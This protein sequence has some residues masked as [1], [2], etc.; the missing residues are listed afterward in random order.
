MSTYLNEA[1][2]QALFKAWHA[3]WRKGNHA[4][5]TVNAKKVSGLF[6]SDPEERTYARYLFD[7]LVAEGY[8]AIES[9]VKDLS[10]SPRIRIPEAHWPLLAE[11][12]GM[13]IERHADATVIWHAALAFAAQV[14]ESERLK[15]LQEINAWLAQPRSS[16]IRP[17]RMRAY[18]IHGNEKAWDGQ[19]LLHGEHPAL[20]DGQLPL[21]VLNASMPGLPVR[22]A[23]MPSFLA[24]GRR[25]LIVENH[26]AYAELVAWNRTHCAFQEVVLGMGN[27]VVLAADAI[28]D[29][30]VIADIDHWEYAGDLDPAG[31]RI[32]LDLQGRMAAKGETLMPWLDYWQAL[33]RHPGGNAVG[34]M[35]D[36][37]VEQWLGFDLAQE[38]RLR[39]QRGE[40]V[41]QEALTPAELEGL[42]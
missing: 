24:S 3:R 35:S 4:A 6:P 39:W 25:G 37:S 15:Q 38:V 34:A 27:Q 21:S 28:A 19:V 18:E 20:F 26:H 32:A 29:Y 9:C 22:P 23:T 42:F 5:M 30:G 41:P 40:R 1:P 10:G 12:F 36:V 11:W 13:P 8:V 31:V 14:R 33:A 2:V 16:D 7:K 17:Y